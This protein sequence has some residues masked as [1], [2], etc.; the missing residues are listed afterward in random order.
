VLD[1]AVLILVIAVMS[2]VV[3]LVTLAA[4]TLSRRL[5]GSIDILVR[6]SG[7]IIVAIAIQILAAGLFGLIEIY[8]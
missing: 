3:Y 4:S 1:Y 6:A 5:G 7:I 8:G 2:L